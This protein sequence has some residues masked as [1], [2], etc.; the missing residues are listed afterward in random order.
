[1]SSRLKKIAAS[2][3]FCLSLQVVPA[4]IRETEGGAA[5]GRVGNEYLWFEAENMRDI[6]TDARNEPRIYPSYILH[7]KKDSPGWGMNGP[8][9]SAEWTQGGESEW[10]SVAASPDETS[11]SLSQE[12]EIPRDGAYKVFARYADWGGRSED[13]TVRLSQNGREVFR[14][15]FG[16][17]D[18]LDRQDETVA[19]WGW[20]FVWDGS[21]AVQ[22][23]KGT[24]RLTLNVERASDA[25]RHVDCLLITNDRSFTP[26]GR[27]KPPFAANEVLKDWAEGRKPVA[28][29]FDAK[30][31]H[32]NL[33]ALWRRPKLAGRDFLIPWN[34]S[35]KFWEL[36]STAQEAERPLYPFATESPE[37]FVQKYKG[38]RDVPIFSS[39]LVVPVFHINA[40]PHYLKEGSGFLR[41]ARETRAPFAVNINYGSLNTSEADGQAAYKLLF[42][43]LREQFIGWISGE[44][45]GYVYPGV[46]ARLTLTPAM[47]RREMLEKYGEAYALELEK[48]WAE[49]FK[50]QTGAMW[51]KLIPAQSTSSTSYAH[52][53]MRW[54]VRLLGLETAAV[55]PNFAMRLAFTRGAA[56]QFGGNFLYYHAPNF[57]DTAS[58]FTKTQN[59]AGP[60]HFFHT[61][62][63]ATMGPSLA[64]Y[65]KS[66]YF[67]FMGG[68]SAVYLE[69]GYDQFFKPAPGEHPFQ[70]NPLGRITDE[71]IRYAEKHPD[72][73]EPYTP[74]A[75]LLDPAHGFETTDWPHWPFGVSQINR[76]DRALRELF[77]AAYFPTNVTEGEPATADRQ[78]YV[79]SIFGDIFDVLVSSD[80]GREAAD[81]YRALIVGGHVEWSKAWIEKLQSYVKKGG[82]VVVNASQTKGLPAEFMGVR[83]KGS[84]GEDD[85]ASCSMHGD[86]HERIVGQM[87]RYEKVEPVGA[88]VLIRSASGDPLATVKSFGL[89]KVI[90][91]A[92]PD[93]LGLDER[94]APVAAHLL[95]HLLGEATPVAVKGD[96]QRL[97][98]RTERGWIITL[99]NNRGVYKPQQGMAE[100]KRSEFAEVEL[101]LRGK[102]IARAFELTPEGRNEIESEGGSVLLKVPPGG[103]RIIELTPAK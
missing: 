69:Q 91:C 67:Y 59:F 24:A 70:L 53:L 81:A 15:D 28:S 94:F 9:V 73:G 41:Y 2:L 65:R 98:N 52:A 76:S 20:A 16:A 63:G 13:F 74:V 80:D 89:G 11:A 58:T 103:V 33:P 43:D 86:K 56:R 77:G 37:E 14:K 100:V 93:M 50:T 39:G 102:K 36:Y 49:I 26:E 85:A 95:V 21:P 40:L 7:T 1:M 34:I 82:V 6:A 17:R 78:A 5:A 32:D 10:N 12:L 61:R 54:G 71:F 48:K 88:D 101:E 55:Q 75:F 29:L 90:Y 42:A 8:G 30:E 35:E 23:K 19:Y 96:V 64:W 60:E 92:V 87:F 97:L 31:A 27:Q 25:R 62:Y 45:I 51:N 99:I 4:Q 18:V 47:S 46:A 83:A 38:A 68:A 79:N 22:L 72:R 84:T 66:F 3:I 57:G 44:S